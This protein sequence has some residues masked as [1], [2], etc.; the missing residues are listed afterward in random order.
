MLVV[1]SPRTEVCHM[2]LAGNAYLTGGWGLDFRHTT[3]TT[4]PDW[5]YALDLIESDH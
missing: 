3:Q 1:A 4:R 2:T 5:N